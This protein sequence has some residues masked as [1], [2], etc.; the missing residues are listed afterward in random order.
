M[1]WALTATYALAALLAVN[2][3]RAAP[4]APGHH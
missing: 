1:G 3:L 4:F 2:V